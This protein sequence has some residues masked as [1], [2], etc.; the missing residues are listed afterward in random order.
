RMDYT[1]LGKPVNLA[2]RLQS[3]AKADQILITDTTRSL[4]EQRV[5]CS[6]VDEVQPKGFSRPVKFHSVDGLKAGHE[7]ESASLSRTLDHIEVNV[8][9]SSDI[10]AAMRELKQ[11]QEELE[12]QIGNASQ[13]ERDEA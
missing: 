11:I 9:D 2:A 5:D 13:K 12:E 4:V 6:F 10:P 3:L 7:R 8:L 1:V